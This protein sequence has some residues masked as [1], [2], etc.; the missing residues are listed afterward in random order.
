MEALAAAAPLVVL[1]YLMGVRRLPANYAALSAAL[2]AMVMA[3]MVWR[4]PVP[5]AVA[6]LGNG[7]CFGLFPIVW[8]VVNGL[9][10]FNI[11][12]ES[13]DFDKMKSTLTALTED[14][15]LQALLIAF[16]FG[17]FLE[18]TVGFGTP[19][20][21]TA[22]MLIGL[23]FEPM[24]A[25]L[26]CLI[27]NTVPGA[28]SAIGIPL[29]IA[30][31][32]AGLDVEELSQQVGM[33]LPLLGALLPLW[34]TVALTGW[35]SVRPVLPAL[36]VTGV[37]FSFG[38]FASSHWLN[39]YL[40]GIATAVLTIVA[41]IAVIWQGNTQRRSDLH[42]F[43]SAPAAW[44]AYLILAVLIFL[45]AD[46]RWLGFKP[47]LEKLDGGLPFYQIAWPYLQD[48]YYKIPLFS[49]P[50]TAVFFACLVSIAIT[51]R[52]TFLQGICCLGR[53]V[54]QLVRPITT[55]STVL[56]LAYLMNFSG[57]S[58][59]IGQALTSTGRAYPF[60][61]PLLG[62]LGAFLTGGVASSNALFG[63]M[64]KTAATG[65]GIDPMLTVAANSAGA[66]TGKMVSAQSLSVL[67]ALPGLK[68]REGEVFRAALPHSLAM[69][70]LL[71]I[72]VALYAA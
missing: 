53:T 4:V 65:I 68:N 22:A 41:M 60:F 25:A 14:R 10:L 11:T 40:S 8:I 47:L 38:Q 16:A 69:V 36:I 50:G 15:R 21:I 39:V 1:A 18:A 62:W 46:E 51:P 52:Y 26:V 9:W 58:A 56:G 2:V 67:A 61:S 35:N 59:T 34:I 57:M 17:S 28:F 66:A 13:G 30:A 49:S 27:A 55:I 44:R 43:N 12:V 5:Q 33:I 63:V 54:V 64:Q 32:V 20:A 71:G 37:A 70:V 7:F 48:V 24:K 31:R 72:V 42:R 6:V 19:V 45:W 29:I 3:I 23:G